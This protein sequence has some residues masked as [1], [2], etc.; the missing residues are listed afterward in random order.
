MGRVNVRSDNFV[1]D[2]WPVLEWLR[3]REP[4]A[5]R[6]RDFTDEAD[7]SG[8]ELLMTWINVGEVFYKSV[9]YF[10]EASA[11]HFQNLLAEQIT[12]IDVDREMVQHAALLK[13]R[14][15]IA[16]ADCFAAALAIRHN[17]SVV[18]GHPD[19]LRLES[20]GLLNLV[21]LGQ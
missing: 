1:I 12:F 21:W 17:A 14:Y 18:T 8:A 13:G 9:H 5:S 15:P 6:F 3:E 16:Y 11:T 19:F 20:A 10:G 7:A 4:A 2:S